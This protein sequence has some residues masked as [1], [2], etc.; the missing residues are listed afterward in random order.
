MPACPT[1]PRRCGTA[2]PKHHVGLYPVPR[3]DGALE[4]EIAPFRAQ[5][6]SVNFPY[7]NPV[8]YE[9]ITRVSAEIVRQRHWA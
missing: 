5:T 4:E 3:L 2:S 8:P 1:G 9:L 7:T 6:D